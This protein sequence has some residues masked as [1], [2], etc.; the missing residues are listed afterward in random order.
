MPQ[1]ILILVFLFS[2]NQQSSDKLKKQLDEMLTKWH[3]AAAV[4]DSKT[5]FGYLADD[6][7]Y[8]MQH[9]QIGIMLLV[10]RPKSSEFLS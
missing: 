7:I 9:G 4:A 8:P 10:S 3:H 6:A 1:T 5:Y 2:F